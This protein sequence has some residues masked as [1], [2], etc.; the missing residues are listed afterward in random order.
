MKNYLPKIIAAHDLSGIGKASLTA[1]VPILSVMGNYVCPLQTAALS[2]ITGV[3]EGYSFTDL[4]KHMQETVNHWEKLGAKFDYIYSGFLGNHSQ[5]DIIIDA[6]K[7]FDCCLVVDP[8]FADDGVLYP[9]MTNDMVHNMKRLVSFA[10]II[11][12]NITEAMYLLGETEV[13]QSFEQIKDYLL[14]LTEMGPNLVLITSCKVDGEMY[15]CAYNKAQNEFITVDC[16]YFEGSYHGTGDVFTTVFLGGIARGQGPKEAI[17][18]AVDFVRKAI[19]ITAKNNI[20][21]RE[22]IAIEKILKDLI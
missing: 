15:V 8:V 21:T 17:Q 22:G 10:D 7:K 11:T 2:S 6:K 16:K 5:V 18:L 1:V 13:P 9:T 19:E 12:P 4:T 14:R 3:Y 20:D